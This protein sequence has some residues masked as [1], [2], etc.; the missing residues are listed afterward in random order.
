MEENDPLSALVIDTAE[1]AREELAEVLEP[2]LRLTREGELLLQPAF[3]SLSARERLVAALLGFR[4]GELLGL[5]D[6]PGVSPQEIERL[7]GMAGGTV[8]PTLTQL[9]RQRLV[10]RED[11]QYLIPAHS[12]RRAA[13]V[14]P[15]RSDRAA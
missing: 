12:I 2:Y 15:T 10:A 8:R 6:G 7:T 13:E 11:G 1:V 3:E 4:A 14:L 5:R 9:L